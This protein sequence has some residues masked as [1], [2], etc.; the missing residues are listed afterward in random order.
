VSLLRD[1]GISRLYL[2]N[3][4]RAYFH[5]TWPC[6]L[7][8]IIERKNTV[9]EI[10]RKV[11]LDNQKLIHSDTNA[12][13]QKLAEMSQLSQSLRSSLEQQTKK[14]VAVQEIEQSGHNHRMNAHFSTVREL[15]KE[16]KNQHRVEDE[17]LLLVEKG[18]A[19]SNVVVQR[20]SLLVEWKASPQLVPV[21]AKNQTM[22]RQANRSPQPIHLNPPIV[23]W[24]HLLGNSTLSKRGT[25]CIDAITRTGQKTFHTG[26]QSSQTAE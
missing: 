6:L 2:R 19:I 8:P 20:R 18:T 17:G 5:F 10:N 12:L 23:D 9:F 26:N 14:F 4:V 15:L 3:S 16:I 13:M 21:S 7:N 1:S 25:G 11:V 24:I 22:Q